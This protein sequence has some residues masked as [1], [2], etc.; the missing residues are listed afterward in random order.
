MAKTHPRQKG[1]AGPQNK[2][3]PKQ[4]TGIWWVAGVAV[5]A[6]GILVAISLG[7]GRKADTV[8]TAGATGTV[9]GA[10]TT[11]GSATAKLKVVEYGDYL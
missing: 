4:S 10:V 7:G 11:R 9:Q 1:K 5:V 2:K 8:P 3:R 6:A